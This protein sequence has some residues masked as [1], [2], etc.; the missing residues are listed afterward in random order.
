MTGKYGRV[1]V[2]CLHLAN[3]R[4]TING[5]AS[6]ESAN[7]LYAGDVQVSLD[8]ETVLWKRGLLVMPTIVKDTLEGLQVIVLLSLSILPALIQSA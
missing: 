6:L 1:S 4:D 5:W 8:R 7:L 3:F 2:D